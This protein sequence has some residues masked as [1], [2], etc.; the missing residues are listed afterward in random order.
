MI[1][2]W[3]HR[4]SSKIE[5][6]KEECMFVK[7]VI[8]HLNFKWMREYGRWNCLSVSTDAFIT[9]WVQNLT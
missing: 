2:W 4:G 9:H 7:G 3:Y 8:A 6:V 5:S 1:E